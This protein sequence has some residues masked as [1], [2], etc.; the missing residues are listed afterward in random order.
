MYCCCWSLLYS[1]ILPSRADSLRSHVILH[2]WIAFYSA[3]FN[4]HR[5][6]VL[7]ALAWLV[8]HET[9]ATIQPCTML[10]QAK[11][12]MYGACVFSCNPLLHSWQNDWDLLRAT[13]APRGWNGYRSKS[14]HRKLTLEKKILPPLLRG[15]EP[16]TFR[17]QVRRSNYWAIPVCC[18]VC[19]MYSVSSLPYYHRGIRRILNTIIIIIICKWAF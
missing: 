15:F 16:A 19:F 12:H 14:H 13:A 10:L 11:P 18:N 3:F 4:I 6:G 17:S 8:P 2:E 7:T 9:A 1:A 5:N